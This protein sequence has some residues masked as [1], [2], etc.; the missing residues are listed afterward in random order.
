MR[1]VTNIGVEP[2]QT[3]TFFFAGSDDPVRITLRYYGL[4]EAW[5]MDI[6]WR[7]RVSSG[8][9]LSLGVL[10]ILSTNLPFDFFVVDNG[11]TGIDPFRLDDFIEGRCSL[12]FMEPDEMIEIRGVKVDA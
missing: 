11:N 4:I 10:H 2:I 12:G 6:R 7:D 8:I 5:Y 1:F 9:K 3:Q